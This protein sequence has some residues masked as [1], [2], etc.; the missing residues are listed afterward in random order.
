MK[1]LLFPLL[2]SI[3]CLDLK[4]PN[5]KLKPKK[6]NP[7]EKLLWLAASHRLPQE[8][9]FV[10]IEDI[11]ITVC[12]LLD[13]EANPRNKLEHVTLYFPA[14]NKCHIQCACVLG[15]ALKHSEI[16]RSSNRYNDGLQIS[17]A[18]DAAIAKWEAQS[19]ERT[20]K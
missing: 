10:C 19:Q 5:L 7:S 16:R 20:K 6:Y 1:N 9:R 13:Q 3:L 17:Q 4:C 12:G 14:A 2:F 18:V 11:E 15:P 8:Q